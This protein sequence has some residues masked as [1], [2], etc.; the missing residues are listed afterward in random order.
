MGAAVVLVALATGRC[1]SVSGAVLVAPAVWGGDTFNGIYRAV[2]WLGAHLLPGLRVTGRNLNIV[3]TDNRRVIEQLRAD[4]LVIKETRIDALHGIVGLMDAALAAVPRTRVP[5]LVLYG[6]R[7]EVIP[8]R[9]LCELSTRLGDSATVRLYPDG[10]HLLLRDLQARVVW[11]DIAGWLAGG[12]ADPGGTA[13]SCP[14]PG[15][16]HT[17][18]TQRSH[19]GKP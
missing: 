16:E 1:E 4:P 15:R 8:D 18:A 10:Y 12:P 17:S 6:A 14:V 2:L 7:D 19:D 9:S 3:V 5:L 13:G 11:Y